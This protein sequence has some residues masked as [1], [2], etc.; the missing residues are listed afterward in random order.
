MTNGGPLGTTT[1]LALYAY[2]QAFDAHDI[3]YA[4]AL[5]LFQILLIAA[6]FGIVRGIAALR[7]AR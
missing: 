5:A 7:R 4:S 1:S 2:K 3:G 6:L